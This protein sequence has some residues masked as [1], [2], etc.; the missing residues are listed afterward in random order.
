[1]CYVYSLLKIFATSWP[2][3][4][5]PQ[6]GTAGVLI[7]FSDSSSLQ[8]SAINGQMFDK[9]Q[10]NCAFCTLWVLCLVVGSAAQCSYN[11]AHR[12]LLLFQETNTLPWQRRLILPC[13][14]LGP[15]KLLSNIETI[16]YIRIAKA[17]KY[18]DNRTFGPVK[19]LCYN[20]SLLYSFLSRVQCTCML[21]ESLEII[22][23]YK[24]QLTRLMR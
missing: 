22:E 16:I 3:I 18:K 11:H 14:F 15:V 13:S 4:F 6:C 10:W 19:L 1:M 2:S 17:I 12:T 5:L 20:E 8:L 7:T 21:F 24:L 23:I 9:F